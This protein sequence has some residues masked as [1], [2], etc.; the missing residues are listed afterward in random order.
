[1][2]EYFEYL[3]IGF[4]ALI[5]VKGIVPLIYIICTKTY[6]WFCNTKIYEWFLEKFL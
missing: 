6:Q 2:N 4:L 3:Y 1:M 5:I